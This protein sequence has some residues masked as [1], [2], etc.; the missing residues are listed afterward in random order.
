MDSQD[1]G[2]TLYHGIPDVCSGPAYKM[3]DWDLVAPDPDGL[4]PCPGFAPAPAC[5]DGPHIPITR[6]Q[7]LLIPGLDV[8]SVPQLIYQDLQTFSLLLFQVWQ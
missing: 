3:D 7:L 5:D 4:C 1:P 8:P 6:G 2:W